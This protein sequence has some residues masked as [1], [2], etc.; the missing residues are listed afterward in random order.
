MFFLKYLQQFY[1][2]FIA[3]L[4]YPFIKAT[5]QQCTRSAIFHGVNVIRFTFLCHFKLQDSNSFIKRLKYTLHYI[6]NEEVLQDVIKTSKTIL[7]N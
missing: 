3:I 5:D 2:L 6:E 1:C 4:S 7:K